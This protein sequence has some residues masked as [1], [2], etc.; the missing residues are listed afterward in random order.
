M[1]T[2]NL[3]F[4]NCFLYYT[5]AILIKYENNLG[6]SYWFLVCRRE[7]NDYPGV[8]ISCVNPRFY[9]ISVWNPV[10]THRI[11]A[12][13]K[14]DIAA[15][16]TKINKRS[17]RSILL[18]SQQHWLLNMHNNL[19]FCVR[20]LVHVLQYTASEHESCV[21]ILLTYP[22]LLLQEIYTP[23]LVYRCI[24]NEYMTLP[25]LVFQ[26]LFFYKLSN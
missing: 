22:Y 13:K 3:T 24:F 21:Q 19:A 12:H 20:K 10:L 18:T 25:T 7:A 15:R 8:G 2:G 6:N 11:P 14:N 4:Y 17:L 26:S 16:S 5:P 23:H 1:G 9:S